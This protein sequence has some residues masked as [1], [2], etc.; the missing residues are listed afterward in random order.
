MAFADEAD[1]QVQL[2]ALSSSGSLLATFEAAD[3]SGETPGWERFGISA[4]MPGGTRQ[5][6]VLITASTSGPA[7][8]VDDL[9]LEPASSALPAP[10]PLSHTDGDV[11]PTLQPMI[12]WTEV[13]AATSYHLQVAA[14]RAFGDLI[15]DTM[16]ASP[17]YRFADGLAYNRRYFWRGRA[18]S[19]AGQS[20]WSPTWSFVPRPAEQYFDDEFDDQALGSGWFWIREDP[21]HWAFWGPHGS[22]AITSQAG[23]LL[24]DT[25]TARDLLL[26]DAPPDNFAVSAFVD[27][28]LYPAGRQGGLLAYQDDDNYFKIMRVITETGRLQVQAEVDGLVVEEASTLVNAVLPSGLPLKLVRQ[29]DTMSGYYSVDGATWRPLGEPVTV[30]WP[31]L[32]IGLTAYN[33][34][35]VEESAAFFGWFRV[36]PGCTHLQIDVEPPGSG[37][38]TQ[39][40]GD[41]DGGLGHSAGFDV[42]LTANP[43]PGYHFDAWTGE[44]S[45]RAN[46]LS[47]TL[48]REM[49]LT[50]HFQPGLYLPLVMRGGPH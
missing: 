10:L 18:V 46:P 42:T 14:D 28:P 2:Q 19:G 1:L 48:H 22:L 44:V 26:R 45:S 16:T 49:V 41:C 29:G 38:V 15:L 9:A 47:F 3:Y 39:Y 50:A 23:D 21:G 25:N 33:Q 13:S 4:L 24:G 27:M 8:T 34:P 32:K 5:A 7:V 30:A 20:G 17:F 6:R 36:Q 37:S 35:G 40:P 11:T 43:A 31:D 12:E